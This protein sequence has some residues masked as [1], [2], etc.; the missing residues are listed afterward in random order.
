MEKHRKNT[1]S[2]ARNVIKK[3][4]GYFLIL[5]LLILL[6]AA[7]YFV[8]RDALINNS[9]AQG[10]ALAKSYAAE[11]ISNLTTL[12]TLLDF[13]ARTIDRRTEE[14]GMTKE[15]L[16]RWIRSYFTSVQNVLGEHVV[17]P[18]V[19]LDG[20]MIAAETEDADR[21]YDY[22]TMPWYQAMQE[23]GE[24]VTYTDVYTDNVYDVPVI[25]VMKRCKVADAIISFNIFPASFQFYAGTTSLPKN[26]SLYVCDSKGNLLDSY[27]AEG[28]FSEETEQFVKTLTE[29][30]PRNENGDQNT[31]MLD[32][33]ENESQVYYSLLPNGW[34]TL[35]TVPVETVLGSLNRT[36]TVFVVILAVFFCVFVGIG[37]RD[38]RLNMEMERAN[39]IVRVLGD[40]YYATYRINLEDDTYEVIKGSEYIRSKL[41]MKGPY[42]RLLE[43]CADIIEEN[44]YDEFVKT[45]SL[46]N[47][48]KLM[49]SR[50]KDFGGDFQRLFGD[51]YRWVNV[52]IL[53][54]ESLGNGEAVLCFREIQLEKQHQLQEIEILETALENA[55]R[56]EEAKYTFFNNMS[57]DMR[58]PLN[59]II[60]LT[61]LMEKHLDEKETTKN[62]IEKI[63]YS[64]E[65]LLEL[66]ND[67]LDMSRMEQGMMVLN[68]Q[69]FDLKKCIRDCTDMFRTQAERD[70]KKFDVRFLAKD[71]AVIGDSFRIQQILNNLLSNAFKFTSEGDRISVFVKQMSEREYS[72]YMIRVEDS[73]IGMSEKFVSQM[74]EPYARETRFSSKKIDGTG[75]G[76][77]I[78]KN[79]ITQMNG[80]I[81]VRSKLGYGTVF[82]IVVPFVVAKEETGNKA[83]QETPETE[84]GFSMRGCKILVAEDNEINM[85]IVREVLEMNGIE[86]AQAWNGQ[87]AVEVFAAS[88]PHEITA[89]LMDMQ[90]PVMDGCQAAKAIRSMERSDAREIPI[91]AVTANAFSED[92]AATAAAGMNA[93]IAKPIDYSVLC[94]TLTRLI[95]GEKGAGE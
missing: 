62:Y 71:T 26:M 4:R 22:E 54:D 94:S 31:H 3:I 70:G 45:F 48:M 95:G 51:T 10:M 59:A 28:T 8:V 13:G 57:H 91:V 93:H 55:K 68:K 36:M 17:D 66:V 53:F 46:D 18:Y 25:S 77:V 65:Q 64:G 5:A 73:G 78:V 19:L 41:P 72:Q 61:D 60:G 76:M 63:R 30:I 16:N 81:N 83:V 49:C 79:L 15:R 14:D 56:S 44:A 23:A 7:C 34:V 2:V 50:V 1:V 11:Q 38:V 52:S 92:I 20:E 32:A 9:H 40:S 67:I 88:K 35:L 58:T 33:G 90:M 42:H 89:V 21:T 47:I 37:I 43:T 74:F 87:E 24:E 85:E 86:V 6:G 84:Q 39:E 80:E 29:E 27:T 69:Q 12:E 82:T 75:L